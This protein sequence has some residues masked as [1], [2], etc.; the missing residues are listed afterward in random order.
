MK[1]CATLRC[2]TSSQAK[3]SFLSERKVNSSSSSS[4]ILSSHSPSETEN[5]SASLIT[6]E[7]NVSQPPVENGSDGIQPRK[8]QSMHNNMIFPQSSSSDSSQV[9]QIAP[10]LTST[11]GGD[12][13]K[14][15]SDWSHSARKRR[16]ML[17]AADDPA[18]T[19]IT[20][21]FEALD[22]IG[23]LVTKNQKLSNMICHL[24][25]IIRQYNDMAQDGSGSVSSF[26]PVLKEM[27]ENAKINTARNPNNHRHSDVMKKFSAALFIYAGPL[28]Y[29]FIEH[30]LSK[31]M[32]SLCT[33]QRH[34]RAEY[35]TIHEGVFR[36]DELSDHISQFQASKSIAISEDTTRIIS[37]DYDVE[38]DRCVGFVLPVSACGLPL[39]DS[40]LAASFTAIENMFKTATLAKYAYVYMAQPLDL[41]TPPFCLA[42]IGSDNKFTAEQVLLRWKYI[43]NECKKRDIM[44]T[45]FSGDG[46]SRIMKAMKVSVSL[47]CSSNDALKA[48]VISTSPAQQ[49]PIPETW[50]EW[51]HT[52][53]KSS[54]VYV[55]DTVHLGVKLKARLLKPSIVLPMGPH[56]LA[57][58]NHFR[59]IKMAFGKDQHNLRERDV[60]HRDKQNFDAV[61]RIVGTLHLLKKIPEAL[62]TCYYVEIIQNIVD[63][64]LDKSL[65]PLE[66]IEKIWYATFFVRYW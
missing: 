21:Y 10:P 43:Y 2:S 17:K 23:S 55:Q 22:E 48:E 36:F 19:Q 52:E 26:A 30:N 56:Y 42:C 46:D 24:S 6:S 18:Q 1:K 47:F 4:I 60:N 29:E 37:R 61:L 27:L 44:V 25:K 53:L 39:V 64:F 16:H 15:C 58:G 45:T 34:I 35:K 40:F 31:S 11:S 5:E 33:V 65:T 62:G 66:R 32:P 20:D 41:R 12:S 13:S 14:M 28:T 57:S 54:V 59:L 8:E 49:I 50:K 63:K 7:S 51:F 3:L 38:T 9:F